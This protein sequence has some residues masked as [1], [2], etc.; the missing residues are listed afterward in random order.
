MGQGQARLRSSRANQGAEAGSAGAATGAG[1][2]G[3]GTRAG[4]AAAVAAGT[5][6]G[7]GAGAATGAAAGIAAALCSAV[8]SLCHTRE[9]SF[10]SNASEPSLSLPP[11][12]LPKSGEHISNRS[13]FP[14]CSCT[15][16]QETQHQSFRF[17]SYQIPPSQSHCQ[18]NS[19]SPGSPCLQ[20]LLVHLPAGLGFL[21]HLH[22]LLPCF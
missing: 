9:H 20:C 17:C 6:A 18:P 21:P 3:A 15:A 10:L 12:S 16:G 1:A 22:L 13:C 11:S 4:A 14:S 19:T 5:G 2:A 7:A 8:I